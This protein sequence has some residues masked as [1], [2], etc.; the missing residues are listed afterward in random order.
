MYTAITLKP[1]LS[2]TK[3]KFFFHISEK[4][5]DIWLMKKVKPFRIGVKS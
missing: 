3:D 2:K 1:Y 5:V 4:S